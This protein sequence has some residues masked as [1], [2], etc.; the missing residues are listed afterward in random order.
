MGTGPNRNHLAREKVQRRKTLH[1]NQEKGCEEEKETLT[2]TRG[3]YLAQALSEFQK[4]SRE[5][6]LLRGFFVFGA[7]IGRWSLA[8]LDSTL[9]KLQPSSR[10]CSYH[11]Q[12]LT[13]LLLFL[14]NPFDSLPAI[15]E[16]PAPDDQKPTTDD[17]RH[18]TS[19]SYGTNWGCSCI[20]IVLETQERVP[21]HPAQSAPRLAGPR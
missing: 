14:K 2:V 4:A 9:F 21:G 12:V 7:V 3:R 6:H 18:T 1:G 20:L 8:K 19:F 15:Q 17:P 16:H 10:R 5:K 11:A 13:G